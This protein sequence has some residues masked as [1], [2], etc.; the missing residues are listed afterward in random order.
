[1]KA[2]LR[3]IRERV[4]SVLR[5]CPQWVAW[6]VIERDRRPTKTPINPHTGELARVNERTTWGSL[7]QALRAC[8]TNPELA[9]VGFV[10]SADDSFC[11]IDLDDCV[12]PA[13]REV[14][15]WAQ[16]LLAKLAS[17]SEI[18]PSGTGVKVFLRGSKP[19]RRCRTKIGDGEIEIYDRDRFFTF[20][21]EQVPATPASVELRQTE[22][23]AIYEQIFG[24]EEGESSTRSR[25]HPAPQLGDDEILQLAMRQRRSG[26]KF[27][28]L[29]QGDWNAYFNSASEADSS[30]I[31]SLAFYSK[32]ERQLDR[33]FRRSGLMRSKWDERHGEQTY[34]GTTIAKALAKVGKQYQPHGG[35]GQCSHDGEEGALG[36]PNAASGR[37]LL[38]TK[39]TLPTAEAFVEQFYRHSHG[40]TLHHY[41]GLNLAWR[42]NRYVEVE[43]NALR[44]Q[45]L[46]W[47]HA[48][49]H[50]TYD[51]STKSWEP[52][53]F[54]ANPHTVGAALESV[55]A[56]AHLPAATQ[57]PAWLD[58]QEH[59]PPTEILA[60]KSALLHLPT[61]KSYPSTPTFFALNAL[62]YDPNPQAELPTV[63]FQ[64]LENLLGEDCE[65]WDLLQEWFGYCLTGDTSFQKM[66]LV[67]GPRR[68]GKGT[69]ARVL[70][71][72]VGASNVCGPT[73]SSLGGP[74]GLQ[75]LIGKSVAIVSD[76]RFSGDIQTVVERLLCIS[77]EDTL[78]IDRKHLGSVTLKLPTRFVFLSNELPRLSDS[79][80]ALAGRFLLL[81]LTNS[82]YGREDR[83]LTE[84]LLSE[85]PGILNWAI[86]G[87]HNLHKR[88]H[89]VQPTSIA[90]TLRDMEDLASPVG[91]FVRE[92]C[93]TGNGQRVSA[94]D[95]Y[96]AWRD[97]CVE[98]GRSNVSTKQTFG[99]DLLAAIPGITVHRNH[100]VGRFYEGIALSFPRG[101]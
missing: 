9:G 49:Q 30:V 16:A 14:H 47:L 37:L 61:L 27:T 50:L 71:R 92:R 51:S 99:R 43:D 2:S 96:Q 60:C 4:P 65:A 13:T 18:S 11:G 79:S 32:D 57:V 44:H 23:N 95:L 7:E 78:T 12:T 56:Y 72:L 45:L 100:D 10:F 17:Y 42:E 98:E 15:P 29:W 90:S 1:M 39:R 58:T 68:S 34:G 55:K 36:K 19:G 21:G 3:V 83:M 5:D 84:K 69:L 38:S 63:W 73:T 94:H 26:A 80:G 97:W 59:Q 93:R 77:G 87:W 101:T 54:P 88:G 35:G 6:K 25:S 91:A 24:K 53:D 40:R 52:T 31:F 41:A 66:L 67:V 62:D 64:F 75:P 86:T 48:A 74:F 33:L 28:A 8:E 82:F 20:T 81:R 46:P 70:T 89:F 22:I 76:A 85:L